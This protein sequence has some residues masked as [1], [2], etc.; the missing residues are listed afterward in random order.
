MFESA[1]R[2]ALRCCEVPAQFFRRSAWTVTRHVTLNARALCKRSNIH[3]VKAELVDEVG[4]CGLAASSSPEIPAPDDSGARRLPTTGER[5]HIEVVE[6]FHNLRGGEVCLKRSEWTR[7]RVRECD[8]PAQDI[9][10]RVDHD[11]ARERRNWNST[12]VSMRG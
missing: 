12:V 11:L 1:S 10:V 2:V 7:G 6:C 4:D 9:V 8:R 3:C 5:S